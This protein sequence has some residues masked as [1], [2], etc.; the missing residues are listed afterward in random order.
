M[1]N[2]GLRTILAAAFIACAMACRPA[3]EGGPP[4]PD[5]SVRLDRSSLALTVE[6]GVSREATLVATSAGAPGPIHLRARAEGSGLEGVET[7]SRESY[8]LV[9]VRS[10]SALAPGAYGGTLEVTACADAPCAER[11]GSPLRVPYTVTVLR[12]LVVPNPVTL[13]AVSG[14]TAEATV[15]VMLPAGAGGFEVAVTAGAGWLSVADRT[16]TGFRVRAA[17]RPRGTYLGALRFTAGDEVRVV[18]VVYQV[19]PRRM[20]V[21]P[22]PAVMAVT[23]GASAR[24][25]VGVALPDDASEFQVDVEAAGGWLTVEDRTTGGVALVARS[26]PQGAYHGTA[27]FRAGDSTV[28]V[29]VVYEVTAPPGGEYG[30]RVAPASLTFTATEGATSAVQGLAVTPPSWNPALEARSESVPQGWL[31]VTARP[32]GY[33]VQANASALSQGTYTGSLILSGDA[34]TQELR[35]LVALTVGP[36]LVRPPDRILTITSS[37]TPGDLLGTASVALVGGPPRGWTASSDA[38]WLVLDT[39]TGTTGEALRYRV[40][41]AHVAAMAYGAETS[42]T[43][44]ISAGSTLTPTSFRFTLRN[45]VAEIHGVTPW[46]R[47]AGQA[48]RIL[49]RGRGFAASEPADLVVVEGIGPVPAR[50]LG[51]TELEVQVPPAP[52]GTYPVRVASALDLPTSSATLRLFEP[53]TFPSALLAQVGTKHGLTYDP[54]NKVIHVVNSDQQL[55]LRYAF[56]GEAWTSTQR[57]FPGLQD[58]GVSPDGATLVA[59]TSG[60]QIRLLDPDTLEDRA[61]HQDEVVPG[62]FPEGGFHFDV[63]SAGLPV[64]NDGRVWL[65]RKQFIGYRLTFFDLATRTFASAPLG[66]LH[67]DFYDAPKFSVSRDG[68]RL[69]LTQSYSSGGPMLYL[70]A[71]DGVLHESPAATTTIYRSASH[72]EDAGRLLVDTYWVFDRDH[73]MVGSIPRPGTYTGVDGVLAPD[74]NRAYVLSYPQYWDSPTAPPPIVAV[75][76]T[77]RVPS[78]GPA[79][80]V[81]GYFRLP[82]Y[83]TCHS[84][85]AGGSCYANVLM[86]ITPDGRTLIIAGNAAMMIVPL[87]SSL[88]PL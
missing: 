34:F 80:P 86:T 36:G 35:V 18:Q 44:A 84:S 28:A 31:T 52:A 75:Y 77:S 19:A 3:G 68:D 57:A 87:P 24:T 39:A 41:P 50:R 56:S 2:R 83:P 37:T 7:S 40:D 49:V 10:G 72:S 4:A 16:A 38:A 13:G 33:D 81:L 55:L 69:L 21:T 54:V 30:I 76:D 78:S 6:E 22:N 14:S 64:T 70:D 46:A 60:G 58:I 29:P 74:G 20:V 53:F 9:T 88:T 82:D 8:A 79:L 48:N 85:S 73:A 25:A 26:L 59:A 71:I 65:A 67:P 23:S 45:Q 12:R 15:Q 51:D 27:T 43:V 66:N 42:A 47:P 62:P 32:E 11:I 5:R 61:I 17:A 1:A 63:L